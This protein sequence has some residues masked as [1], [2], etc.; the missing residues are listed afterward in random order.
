MAEGVVTESC[1][2]GCCAADDSVG[3]DH[4]PGQLSRLLVEQDLVPAAKV[5]RHLPTCQAH[6][7]LQ[8]LAFVGRKGLC[9]VPLQLPSRVLLR[10]HNYNFQGPA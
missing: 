5:A 7:T 2:S 9:S 8:L 4:F 6:K 10:L 1:S 3:T